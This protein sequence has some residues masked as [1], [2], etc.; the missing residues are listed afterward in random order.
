MLIL[1]SDHVLDDN[2]AFYQGV[3]DAIPLAEEGYIVTFGIKPT[4]PETGFGYIEQGGPVG[5]G[6]TVVRFVENRT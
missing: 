1:P 2:I 5:R 3:L 4:G 6:Y